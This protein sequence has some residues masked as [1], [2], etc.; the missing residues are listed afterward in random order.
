MQI[1]KVDEEDG[2]DR[3]RHAKRFRRGGRDDENEVTRHAR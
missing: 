2:H 1:D 3:S